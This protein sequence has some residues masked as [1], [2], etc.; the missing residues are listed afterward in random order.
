VEVATRLTLV[1]DHL[2]AVLTHLSDRNAR[3]ERSSGRQN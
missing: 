2:V 3:A 1:Q